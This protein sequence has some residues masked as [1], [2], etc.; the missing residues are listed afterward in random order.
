[1][2]A[3]QAVSSSWNEQK[4]AALMDEAEAGNVSAVEDL[5]RAS[6]DLARLAKT[7]NES[8][9]GLAEGI[10]RALIFL[11]RHDDQATKTDQRR[12]RL[13]G[14]IALRLIADSLNSTPFIRKRLMIRLAM[15]D[16]QLKHPMVSGMILN[17]IRSAREAIE[18]QQTPPIRKADAL[19]LLT[20]GANANSNY[21]R[22]ALLQLRNG[23]LRMAVPVNASDASGVLTNQVLESPRVLAT[24]VSDPEHLTGLVSTHS[25]P[26]GTSFPEGC[27]M[28]AASPWIRSSRSSKWPTGRIIA[29]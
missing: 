7:L 22:D 17:M 23:F 9:R 25:I 18:D 19:E 2:P 24:K 13:D 10:L 20:V 21:A 4:L 5:R 27:G 11:T 12:I 16:R 6:I 8:D 14:V 3:S 26:S 15:L 29:S 28:S 1:M